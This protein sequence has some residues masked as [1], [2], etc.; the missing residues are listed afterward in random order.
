MDVLP[1]TE[2]PDLRSRVRGFV[3]GYCLGDALG[4][5]PNPHAGI[6]P[7]GTPSLL[8]LSSTEGV[9]RALVRASL[10][11]APAGVPEACWHATARW[12]YR[13]RRQT[14][15]GVLAWQESAPSATWP[16]GWLSQLSLLQGGRGSAPAV[17]EA[18]QLGSNLDPRPGESASDSAGDL[19]LARTLPVALL[20]AAHR[21]G[22]PQ[23][24]DDADLGLHVSKVARDV[25]AYSHGLPAQVVAV[26]LTR[27]AVKVLTTGEV[28]PLA[29]L[30]DLS[31]VYEGVPGASE[32][33][34][35]RVA[36]RALADVLP[37]HPRATTFV[38]HG[39]PAG[40]RTALRALSEGA[41]CALTHAGRA[42][43]AGAVEDL[44]QTPEPAAGAVALSL[45]GAAHGIEA[46]PPDAVARLDVGHVADQ[47]ANDLLTQTH[48]GPLAGGD[49][50]AAHAWLERY[51]A[52]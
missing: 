50:P 27:T 1:S 51:P 33:V 23:V 9:I 4:R 36:L 5:S 31:S 19:V 29:D 46:L 17:E 49:T 48:A 8:F 11:G 21:G 14:L 35:A 47:L 37:P 30:P 26:A 40:P 15:P 13:A 10:S 6:L 41:F 45:L 32:V 39:V 24:A 16:D 43:V 25:A 34:R 28:Q 18:L 12:A 44:L 22:A 7:V 2:W 38:S 3:V 52:W 42:E 20:A